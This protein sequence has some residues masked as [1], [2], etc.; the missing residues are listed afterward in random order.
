MVPIPV[1]LH[2]ANPRSHCESD[3]PSWHF[4]SE[5]LSSLAYGWKVQGFDTE[6]LQTIISILT[7]LPDCYDLNQYSKVSPLP[8]LF[9]LLVG[10]TSQVVGIFSFP[11][12]CAGPD[13]FYFFFPLFFSSFFCPIKFCKVF[14][15]LLK[16]WGLL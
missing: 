6:H 11:S 15:A 8:C 16:P 3:L 7:A 14:L 2:I 13:N 9:S 5:P 4:S 1:F 10:E 12:R